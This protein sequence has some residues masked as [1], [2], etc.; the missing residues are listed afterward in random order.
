MRLKL[1]DIPEEIIIEY[2]LRE[3][4][5]EDG[6]VYCEIQKGMYGLPQVG[7]IVQDLHQACLAK[8]GYHQN[9]T[10]PVD[11]QNKEDMLHISR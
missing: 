7:L 8:V 5:A 6:Y 1:N 2:K 3:I 9:Y 11:T 4:A 10:W